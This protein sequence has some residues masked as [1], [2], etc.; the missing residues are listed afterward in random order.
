M[1]YSGHKNKK[2]SGQGYN[3]NYGL[4][5]LSYR[6]LSHPGIKRRA[7]MFLPGYPLHIYGR[8]CN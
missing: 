4:S 6:I 2:L 7:G 5:Y 1:K 3:P 8:I